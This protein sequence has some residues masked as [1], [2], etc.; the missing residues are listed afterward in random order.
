MN[1]L[2]VAAWLALLAGVAQADDLAEGIKAWETQDFAKAHTLLGKLAEVGNPEA[3]LMVGEMYGFGE[4]VTEDPVI[5]ERWISKAQANGHKGAAESLNTLKQRGLR[6]QDIA[7]YVSGY[8][9][10]DVRLANYGCVKPAFPQESRTQNDIRQVK[11]AM[12]AWEDCY[13]RFG[14]GLVAAQPAGRAI[15]QDVAKLM[16]LSELQQAQTN[17]DKIYAAVAMDGDR[18]ARDVLAAYDKW[19]NSTKE[20]TM[21]MQ[22]KTRND[23]E[24]RNRQRDIWLDKYKAVINPANR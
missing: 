1:K 16:S 24:I 17:M 6:K 10:D 2:V 23:L 3:Q 15:P 18:E 19:V 7:F 4:G 14:Q 9:G 5:A 13:D 12:D 22:Q 11:A 20:W 8:Q 21:A